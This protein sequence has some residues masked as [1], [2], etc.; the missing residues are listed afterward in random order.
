[1]E[2]KSQVYWVILLSY[3]IFGSVCGGIMMELGFYLFNG[4]KWSALLS[5]MF[6][7]MSPVFGLIPSLSSG[8]YLAKKAA[9]HELFYPGAYYTIAIGLAALNAAIIPMFLVPAAVI[10]GLVAAL[11]YRIFKPILANTPFALDVYVEA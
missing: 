1:M 10:G 8:Y 7:L 11:F 5:G 4:A 2:T 9:R 6:L 3:G